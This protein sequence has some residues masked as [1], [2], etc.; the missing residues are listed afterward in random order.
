MS[1][2][3]APSGVLDVLIHETG[4]DPITGEFIHADFYAVEKG[5][6]LRVSA[7]IVWV[8]EAPAIKLGGIVVKVLHELEVEALPQ[9]LPSRG[10]R[11]RAHKYRHRVSES[12]NTWCLSL[13]FLLY[14][15]G[16]WP[17]GDSLS[18]FLLPQ[19]S[20]FSCHLQ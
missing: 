17:D 19:F 1:T 6:A 5:K 11:H 10:I 15:G 7:P 14:L 20:F 12:L 2:S 18:L 13:F 4:K 9:D 16:A 3:K 8:G